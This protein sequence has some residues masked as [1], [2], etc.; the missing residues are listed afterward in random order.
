MAVYN[1]LD[2]T[3]IITSL[4]STC[5]TTLGDNISS[6]IK[7]GDFVINPLPLFN[8]YMLRALVQIDCDP[9]STTDTFDKAL[10]IDRM[11]DIC[12]SC[13]TTSS[14]TSTSTTATSY[15]LLENG[16]TLI[17]EDGNNITLE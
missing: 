10:F 6:Q 11:K 1:S 16:N 15:I 14:S 5:G 3:N 12:A 13:N 2:I 7:R 9:N 4:D 8:Y 17:T